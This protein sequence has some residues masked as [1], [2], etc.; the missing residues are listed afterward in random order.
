MIC[1]LRHQ[2]MR[3]Q[4]G[5]WQALIDRPR[6]SRRLDHLLARPASKLGPHMLNYLVA[7][8][9]AFQLFGY[10]FAKLPQGSAAVR[11]ASARRRMGDDF[12]RKILRQWL[13]RSTR[14]GLIRRWRRRWFLRLPCCLLGLQFFQL[15][16]KLFQLTLQLLALG[17]E[18]HSLVLVDDQLQM[19][20]LPASLFHL[21]ASQ[22]LLFEQ[23]VALRDHHLLQCFDIKR[24]EIR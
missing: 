2:H 14:S 6:R 3:Q 18:D 4:T 19:F 8:R 17:A 21:L 24:I 13:A 7:G 23:L 10:I 5:A 12:A 22:L 9:N 16:L 11:T 1:E 20:N 15:K